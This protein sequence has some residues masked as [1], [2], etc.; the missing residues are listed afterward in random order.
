M[1]TKIYVV[2]GTCNRWDTN[3]PDPWNVAAFRSLSAAKQHARLA[4]ERAAELTGISSSG[5]NEYDPKMFDAS[6]QYYVDALTLE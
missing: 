6:A 2:Y 5:E 4:S 1:S 3:S